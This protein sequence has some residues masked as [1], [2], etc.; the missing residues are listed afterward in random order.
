M[1]KKN[2]AKKQTPQEKALKNKKFQDKKSA[3]QPITVAEAVPVQA[4]TV[5]KVTSTTPSVFKQ[6]A[7]QQRAAYALSSIND[8]KEVLNSEQQKAF[9]S[10]VQALPAMIQMNGLGQA[11]AFYRSHFTATDKSKKGAVAYA[12]LYDILAQWLCGDKALAIYSKGDLLEHIVNH[13][14]HQYRLAQSELQ[15]LLVWLKKMSVALIDDSN[16]GEL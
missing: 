15:S 8:M 2:K 7:S 1:A 14:M 13:D 12:K 3:K 16:E 5:A 11:I 6:T 10:Y 4:K 9:K